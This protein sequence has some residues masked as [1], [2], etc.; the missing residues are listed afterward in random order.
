[1]VPDW[2]ELREASRDRDPHSDRVV[3]LSRQLA[4][5]H[6]ELRRRIRQLRGNL[7][8]RADD[9]VLLVHCLAFCAALTAHHRGE[10]TGMFAELL[11]ER[12]DL[13]GTVAKLVEDH[14]LVASMLGRITELADDA[15]RSRGPALEAIGRELDGLVALMESHF[16]YEERAIGAALDAG[17]RDTAWSDRVFKFLC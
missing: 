10:D 3:A 14:E 16:A 9:D 17:V 12:P 4:Q 5:A 7:A 1:V 11:R 13:S 15:A 6:D 8:E 2:R